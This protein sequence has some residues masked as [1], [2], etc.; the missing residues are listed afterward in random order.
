MLRNQPGQHPPN[1][2]LR[3]IARSIRWIAPVGQLCAQLRLHVSPLGVGFVEAAAQILAGP[4]QQGILPP[5]SVELRAQH[6]NVRSVAFRLLRIGCSKY[7]LELGDID[8]TLAGAIGGE[9]QP[10]RL[11]RSKNCRPVS[12]RD[13]RGFAEPDKRHSASPNAVAV[14]YTMQ[15]N[16][17]QSGGMRAPTAVYVACTDSVKRQCINTREPRF[18]RRV[19][20]AE[21]FLV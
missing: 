7:A 9:A 19:C 5:L 20:L 17:T 2:W 8:L 21:Q 3:R 1:R 10:A 14:R 13:P 6:R 18:R 12:T 16:P 4:L 11:H 15:R